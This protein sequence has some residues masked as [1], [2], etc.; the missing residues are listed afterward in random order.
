MTRAKNGQAISKH[1]R[2][3]AEMRR[4]NRLLSKAEKRKDLATWRRARA[5]L[6]Y[7]QGKTA[8]ELSEDL[9]VARSAINQWNRWFE[10]K[11]TEGL[12]SRKPPGAAPRLSDK[13][14]QELVTLIEAGPIEAGYQTGIWTGPMIGDF[15]RKRFGITY[16]N[17]HIPRLL[18][19]LGF[20]VQRP[21]RRLAKADREKQGEWL[22]HTFPKIKKKRLPVV[23]WFYSGMRPA[24]G[25][26]GRSIRHGHASATNRGSTLTGN[27]KQ[28][29]S[30]E[31]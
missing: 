10:T 28:L 31:Q 29:T 1:R 30:L 20:S 5:V 27:V 26:T 12:Q 22:N 3:R 4:L 7:I 14:R 25:S 11:G 24:S 23:E 2:S 21:R 16:H 8:I 9:N 19:S 13:Q 6:G 17:H 15:I 18:H